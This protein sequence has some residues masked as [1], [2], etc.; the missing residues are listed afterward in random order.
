MTREKVVRH[1][2]RSGNLEG[3]K[4]P[5]SSTG[6]PITSTGTKVKQSA[7]KTRET[8]FSLIEVLTA[9]AVLGIAL[10]AAVQAT[11]Q[12]ARNATYLRD[13]TL[14]HWVAM[15]Q[16]AEQRI[17]NTWPAPGIFQGEET[18]AGRTWYWSLT[19]K[20]TQ[21]SAI[22]RMDIDVFP[23]SNRSSAPLTRLEAYLPKP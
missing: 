4:F 8:G 5:L 10:S 14:A 20:E 15:N 6:E 11:G 21:A 13:R 1:F 3:S 9:L 7:D 19:I 2:R 22:R 16:A 17:R 23:A 18:M 12:Q